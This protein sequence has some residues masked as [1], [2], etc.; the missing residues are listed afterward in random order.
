MINNIKNENEGGWQPSNYSIY[1]ALVLLAA[2]AVTLSMG[3]EKLAEKL[4]IYAYYFMVIG[5]AIR[6]F[7]LLLPEDTLQRFKP[8]RKCNSVFSDSIKHHGSMYIRNT[9]IMFK[10]LCGRLKLYL[11][12][13]ILEISGHI[14]DFIK[15]HLLESISTQNRER[16]K[17]KYSFL[18]RF[19]IIDPGKNISVI[20]EIFRNIA[21]F[22]SG[23]LILF[24]IYGLVID[25]EYIKGYVYNLICAI[26]G[27]FAL[28]IILRVRI[29]GFKRQHPP[30]L[31]HAQDAN[32]LKRQHLD[33]RRLHIIEPGKN[34]A[35]ISDIS[36]NIAIFL[37]VFLL[38][39]LIY[40][41]TID[42][43]FV[44]RYLYNL[45]YAI[46]GCFTVYILLRVRF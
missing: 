10:N 43:W 2:T 21:I 24:L 13:A 9:G 40:G 29:S 38:I 14:S 31:M 7:G 1:I 42:W 36:R 23:V 39:S 35:L 46:L 25:W 12:R 5:V 22:L 34:I 15:R 8:A 41:I 6:F 32:I 20:S 37:S 44:K 27:G 19:H 16:F 4:A 11:R 30:E 26:I 18:Q 28:Y 3:D 33:M 45:I 17:Q